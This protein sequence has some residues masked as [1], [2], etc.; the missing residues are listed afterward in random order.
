MLSKSTY[1]QFPKIILLVFL[2]V[3]FSACAPTIDLSI[4][5][6]PEESGLNFTQYTEE[7][8]SVAEPVI[9]KSGGKID[10]YAPPLISIS[11]DGEKLAY[12]GYKNGQ[13]HIF[14]KN[15][16]GG[17][18]VNQRTFRNNVLDMSYSPDGEWIVFTDQ[19][20]GG[21]E[22]KMINANAGASIQQI[23]NGYYDVGPRFSPN[24]K[25]I[26]FTRNTAR[27]TGTNQIAQSFVIWSFNLETSL[28]TQYTE[29]FTPNVS[30]DG[31]TLIV[32]RNNRE[33]GFGEIWSIN[34]KTGQE[35]LIL[36]DSEKGFSSPQISPDGSRL[37]VVG[38]TDESTDRP[39]NLDLYTIRMDGTGLTQHTF[40]PGHDL[41]GI[42]GP[43]GQYIYL[44]SQRGSEEGRFNIWR[45]NFN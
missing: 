41:S 7:S 11:P 16:S 29:G 4:R 21:Q 13:Y 6:V 15:T 43:D 32:T 38:T 23:T 14:V 27:R 17:R 30:S 5:T 3:S 28:F 33:T 37:L 39:A 2:A 19:V 12:N 42:W 45:M 22:I 10:W 9:R 18:S 8:E 24:G 25:E 35:T 34:I 40:H 1:N 36:S 44:L 20:S 31:E 26:Y